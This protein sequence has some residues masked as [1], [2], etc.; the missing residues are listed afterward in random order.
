MRPP[1]FPLERKVRKV[2]YLTVALIAHFLMFLLP[3]DAFAA[4]YESAWLDREIA[5]DGKAPEWAGREVYFDEGDGL[6]IGFMNDD[7]YLYVYLSTW[8]QQIQ[9]QILMNGLTVWFD[10]KGGKKETF[11]INYPLKRSMPGSR[12]G[13]YAGEAGGNPVIPGTTQRG[14]LPD[15]GSEPSRNTPEMLKEMLGETE[16]SLRVVGTGKEPLAE[17]ELHDSTG[18]DIAAAI[19]IANR[20]LIYELRVPLSPD[21]AIP[22]AVKTGPGGKVG[23]GFKVGTMEKPLMKQ[24]GEAPEGMGEGPGGGGMPGGGGGFPGGG[25]GGG[26]GMGGGAPGG[27]GPR[28][29]GADAKSLDLWLKVALAPSPASAPAK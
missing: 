21:G 15:R 13:T 27:N 11:G 25:P 9:R 2:K 3:P 4:K 1:P 19:D 5:V 22:F 20:T 18:T 23:I 24:P 10:A 17:F 26:G 28:G 29:G 8:H 14:A 12:Q 16:S 7:C 6:K